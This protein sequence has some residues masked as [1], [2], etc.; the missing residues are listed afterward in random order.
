MGIIY[1]SSIESKIAL[2]FSEMCD[3]VVL[4]HKCVNPPVGFQIFGSKGE[5]RSTENLET[6]P[7]SIESLEKRRINSSVEFLTIFL[8]ASKFCAP[9]ILFEKIVCSRSRVLYY[10]LCVCRASESVVC[11]QVIGENL[12]KVDESF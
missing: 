2:Q 9:H 10:I 1:R 5:P 12:A 6:F 4:I 3:R 8:S 7:V 11:V